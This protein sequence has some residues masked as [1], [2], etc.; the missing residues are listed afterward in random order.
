MKSTI[1][2]AHPYKQSYNHA[3]LENIKNGLNEN[4]EEFELIDLVSDGFDPVMSEEDLAGYNKGIVNDELIKLYQKKIN[5][6][7]KLIF[8]FPI[9]WGGMPAIMKGFFDKIFLKNFAYKIEKGRVVGLLNFLKRTLIITTSSRTTSL[10][11]SKW[12]DPIGTTLVES[13]F[14]VV[15]IDN[16]EWINFDSISKSSNEERIYFL[17]EISNLV[18]N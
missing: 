14:K 16:Y 17:D 1:I 13:T 6:A 8:I 5:S 3:I 11:Q 15:G 10:L 18:K 4:N 9:W 12:G 7:D 2:Y